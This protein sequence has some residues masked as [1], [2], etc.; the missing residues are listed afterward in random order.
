MAKAWPPR[1][2][3]RPRSEAGKVALEEYF[4]GELDL[5]RRAGIACREARVADDAERR[6]A[7]RRRA[8]RLAEIRLVEQVEDLD[9]KLYARAALQRHVLNHREVGIPESR[10]VE[11]VASEVSEMRHASRVVRQREDRRRGACAG[12]A[13]GDARIADGTAI[14]PLIADRE[15]VLVQIRRRDNCRERTDEIRSY[16]GRPRNR[17]MFVTMLNGFPVCACSTTTSCQPSLRRLPWNGRSYDMLTET[18]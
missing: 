13:C 18:R 3:R 16:G 17:Q 2:S 8:A 15:P 9:A 10:T 5:P 4:C 1:T 6:A 12:G 7:H 14:E 11:H